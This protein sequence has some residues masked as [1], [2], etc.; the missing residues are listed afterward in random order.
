MQK[1]KKQR[2]SI[3]TR[4]GESKSR[5]NLKDTQIEQLH[6]LRQDIVEKC[7]LEQIELPIVDDPMEKGS[8]MQLPVFDYSQLSRSHQQEMLPSERRSLI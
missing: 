5:I 8:S 2:S 1:M 3:L 6:S 4:T 7:E